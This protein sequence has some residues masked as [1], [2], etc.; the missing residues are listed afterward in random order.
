MRPVSTACMH[1]HL[2]HC[3]NMLSPCSQPNQPATFITGA[4]VFRWDVA[5]IKFGKGKCLQSKSETVLKKRRHWQD[6]R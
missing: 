6:C 1:L 4:V 2:P 5:H 3:C